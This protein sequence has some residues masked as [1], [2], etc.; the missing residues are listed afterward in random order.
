M[1]YHALN[2]PGLST[3]ETNILNALLK[4]LDDKQT[5]NLLRAS[6]YD[7]KR[8]VNQI[9]SIIPPQYYNLGLV[10]G[11]S[12][13]AVDSLA[14]RCKLENFVWA[15]GDIESL[16]LS[17]VQD[18]NFLQTE[19]S[20]GIVSSLIHGVSF[21]V[22]TEGGDDEPAALVHSKD[23][24]TSTG[25]WNNRSRRL[26]NFLSVT[27]WD[28]ETGAPTEFTLYLDYLT[29]TA[30]KDGHVWKVQRTETSSLVPAEP[31]V[32]KPRSGRNF[33]SSR[34]S[35]PLMSI[36]DQALRE[37]I[38]LEGHMDV[39]SFPEM[40]MLGADSSIF[41]NA[42]G[43]MK[44]DWQIVLG[45]IKGIP[46]DP[47]SPQPRADVKQFPAASPEPHLAALNT[48]AKL[49]AREAFLP[50]SSLAIA[51]MSN[52][53]SADAYDASQYEMIAEAEGAV[54]DFSPA[55]R[56]TILNALAI[57]NGL[58]EIPDEWKSIKPK[59][60]NP[61]FQSRAAQADAGVKQISAVPWLAETETGLEL[62]GLEPQQIEQAMADK[63]RGVGREALEALRQRVGTSPVTQADVD[64]VEVDEPAVEGKTSGPT[65]KELKE[66][67]EALG[68]AVRAGVD[69]ESAVET[70]GLQGVKL[71]GALP[72]SLRMP[73]EDV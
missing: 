1:T 68:M 55:L 66:K 20:S 70:L 56:R 43:S 45:R 61:R 9:G 26:V 4:Q 44:A 33:G 27:R 21:L 62:L 73:G 16:G 46:D 23:A 49:F 5:R 71:T 30:N 51:D 60:R 34:I 50:D 54:D 29:I 2:I 59:W 12:G 3:S 41:Q 39:F 69:P 37:I 18:S 17:E 47:A 25:T 14:R 48:F 67:F 6:Y 53:T 7:G 40:W 32:Y 13:K 72:S 31:L 15:D 22:T 36:H 57:N 64:A 24:L 63:R 35:R 58:D 19:I 8:A 28:L 11:W 52:P 10:L 42:D 38:R 65:A